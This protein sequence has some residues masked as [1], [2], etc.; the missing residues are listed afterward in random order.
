MSCSNHAATFTLKKSND[1]I[2]IIQAVLASQRMND[3]FFNYGENP[4]HLYTR[5][6]QRRKGKDNIYGTL[7]LIDS[8]FIFKGKQV[9]IIDTTYDGTQKYNQIICCP[10]VPGKK[11]SQDNEEEDFVIGLGGV[12]AIKGNEAWFE[13]ALDDVYLIVTVHLKKTNDKWEVVDFKSEE[14]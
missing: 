7:S 9:K 10:P 13:F 3:V 8:I 4:L 14:Y 1:T 2:A 12:T 5:I 6:K 11:F